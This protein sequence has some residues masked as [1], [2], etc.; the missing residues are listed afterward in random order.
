M[1]TE[2]E[3]IAKISKESKLNE[4]EILENIKEKELEYSG[5]VSRI[6]AIYIVGRELGIDLI[7]PTDKNLKINNIVFDMNKVEFMGKVLFKSEIKTFTNKNGDGKVA[8]ILLG[9]ETGTIRLSLWNEKTEAITKINVGDVLEI[10]QAYTKKDYRDNPEVRLS[11]YGNIRKVDN[12]DIEVIKTD[13]SNNNNGYTT[14]TL[15][16]I[17]ENDF[18]KIKA[19]IIRLYERTIIH[20]LCP[21][22]KQKIQSGSCEVHGSVEPEKLLVINAIIDDGYKP[23]NAVFFRDT[24]ET[25]IQKNVDK[26]ETEIKEMGERGFFSS[27][28]VLG[29]QYSFKGIIK[30]NKMTD[31][32][33]FLVK[34]VKKLDL[35]NEINNLLGALNENKTTEI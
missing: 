15:D 24:G 7:K 5:L 13:N 9:D 25:I 34:E 23:I 35:V 19:H 31:E 11:K 33:E 3:L 22:C 12:V 27:I 20:Y 2:N 16:K 30:K 8:N 14:T 29:N 28:N 18:I 26:I 1:T 10:L 32:L 4:K 21:T 6:G 17:N